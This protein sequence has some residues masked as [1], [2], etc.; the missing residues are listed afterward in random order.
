MKDAKTFEKIVK[1]ALPGVRALSASLE[2]PDDMDVTRYMVYA[3]LLADSTEKLADRA[4]GRLDRE[5]LDFNEV[6]VCQVEELSVVLGR[7]CPD[8]SGKAERILN[9]LNGIYAKRSAIKLDYLAE[10]NKR[11]IRKH[12]RDIGLCHFAEGLVSMVC[13]EIHAVPVDST[14]YETLIMLKMVHVDST[15]SSVQGF[16]ERIVAQKH[17]GGAPVRIC[18]SVRLWKNMLRRCLSDGLSKR[19]YARLPKRLHRNSPTRQSE[20]CRKKPPE[21]LRRKKHWHGPSNKRS[22]PK[23]NGR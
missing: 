14:L 8:A 21:W 15:P 23:H 19:R 2:M 5:F 7:D 18:S 3:I 17:G 10:M 13:Y 16:L 12:F 6:R 20:K 11:D 1:K 22:R 9:S 4:M